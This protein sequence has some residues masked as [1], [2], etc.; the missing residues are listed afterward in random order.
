[1]NNKMILKYISYVWVTE[2]YIDIYVQ[3][4]PCK[5]QAAVSQNRP[6]MKEKIISNFSWFFH[7]WIVWSQSSL[8]VNNENFL[9][10]FFWN[11]V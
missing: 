6:T 2:E 5:N 8:S 1:M 11:W 3:K 10:N 7:Y 9:L 4:H